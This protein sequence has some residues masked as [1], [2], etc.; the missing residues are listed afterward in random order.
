MFKGINISEGIGIGPAHWQAQL[1]EVDDAQ[2]QEQGEAALVL[3]RSLF[4]EVE[5]DIEQL[6]ESK[7]GTIANDILGVFEAH[8]LMLK[9]P[10][11]ADR[12]EAKIKVGITIQQAISETENE[13]MTLFS[14]LDDP[15]LRER[16]NDIKDICKRLL[17]KLSKGSSA[18]GQARMDTDYILLARELTPS[19]VLEIDVQ[20]VKGILTVTGGPTAH[21]AIVAR[22]LG[23]PAISGIE[24]TFLGA[25]QE[26]ELLIIDALLG[27]VHLQPSPE[28]VQEY[29][30]KVDVLA[31]KH[32][33]LERFR[34]EMAITRNGKRVEVAI[35]IGNYI[36]ALEVK[37][38][39]TD[40]IGL[41][42]TELFY[43]NR[44]D[45]P[46]EEEQYQIYRSVLAE[47]GENP[48]IVRTL[49]IGGDKGLS[50]LKIKPEQNPF[51]GLRAI[52]FCLSR[53]EIF[54]TQL[55]ALLRASTFG[56]LKIMF[57]MISGIEELRQGKQLLAEVR[58][59]LV[60]E[61]IEIAPKI[62]IGIMV[63]IPSAAIQADLLAKEVDFFSIGTNDLVQYTLAVD[64]L[65]DQVSYLYDYFHPAVLR[66]IQSVVKAAHREGKWIGMCG[67]MA[68][69]PLA[70]PL[71]IAMG[72][73]ELSMSSKRVLNAKRVIKTFDIESFH[74]WQKVLEAGT[75]AQ[76]REILASLT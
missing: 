1:I 67:E 35:N 22:S 16:A 69:D 5:K 60:R 70:I 76:V 15:Y 26:G 44:E 46:T 63:E 4:S 50:F 20:H 40:G 34:Q 49:D 68:G 71:L 9:D 57:P 41:F 25:I 19:D 3:V 64:R 14:S 59:E 45:W 38:L 52:R 56:Q 53:P 51:L 58:E 6:I 2:H 43:T 72:I 10:M 11:F 47:A 65:N 28:L 29:E 24:E 36:D 73:D 27:Q 54:R 7:R 21:V 32:A 48:V 61:G 31:Q 23:V 18:K 42:R 8:C 37:K 12:I 62:Q 74:D 55:R 17:T 33:E 66:L 75:P 39:G 30:H 13:L